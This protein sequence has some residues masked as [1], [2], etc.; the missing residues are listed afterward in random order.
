M[1]SSIR[2]DLIPNGTSKDNLVALPGEALLKIG[3]M[4]Q[5]ATAEHSAT[6]KIKATGKRPTLLQGW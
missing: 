4:E 5:D 6:G 2:A 3:A 1:W